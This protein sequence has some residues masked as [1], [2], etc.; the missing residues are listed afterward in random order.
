[1]NQEKL[2]I[3]GW[4]NV[5]L[6]DVAP[7]TRHLL[8]FNSTYESH[9]IELLS[10]FRNVENFA[11]WFGPSIGPK[12]LKMMN[13]LPLRM[14]S[15]VLGEM[16]LDETIEYCPTLKNLTHFEILNLKGSTWDDHKALVKFQRL[17]HLSIGIFKFDDVLNLLEHCRSLR[18]LIGLGVTTDYRTIESHDPRFLVLKG[19]IDSEAEWKRSTNGRIGFWELAEII[20][21]A[22][23][24]EVL[25]LFYFLHIGYAHLF[26]DRR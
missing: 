15:I 25:S 7:F 22:R 2:V 17:T 24:S 18:V 23:H 10:I 6:T 1:M 5:Q 12:I 20:V 16:D 19:D 11:I 14:L 4:Q 26:W 8:V 3:H 21:E 9:L 13:D